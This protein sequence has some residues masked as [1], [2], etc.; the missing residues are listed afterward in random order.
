MATFLPQGL[1]PGLHPIGV[2]H[3]V[4]ILVTCEHEGYYCYRPQIRNRG[5]GSER[6]EFRLSL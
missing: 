1:V 3:K 4:L 5:L 6:V 2:N